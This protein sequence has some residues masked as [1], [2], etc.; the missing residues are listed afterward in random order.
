MPENKENKEEAQQEKKN[1]TDSKKKDKK[2]INLGFIINIVLTAA[3]ALGVSLL[4]VK[5][6]GNN[7][8][9]SLTASNTKEAVTEIKSVLIRSGEY[10][11]FMLKGG[12]DVAVV[13]SLT[14]KV[15]SEGCRQAIVDKSDEIMDTLMIIFLSKDENEL[16]TAAGIELL[17]KQIRSAVDELTGYIGDKEKY[18]IIE[19]YL[20]IKAISSVD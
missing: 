11:T 15:A 9:A 6:L 10:Q 17:K 12:K 1:N 13:D 5:M 4:S 7:K 19:V 20:Y 2:K 14:F 3:I 18:G 16:N 8:Q